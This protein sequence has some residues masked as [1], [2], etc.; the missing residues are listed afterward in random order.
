M[1]QLEADLIAQ[2]EQFEWQSLIDELR[3]LRGVDYI[4]AIT[5]VAEIGNLRRFRSA[6]QLMAYVDLVP[7]EYSS[8]GRQRRG[9]ITRTGNAAVR[10]ALIESAWTYRFPP[11]Q[12]R[13]LQRKAQNASKYARQ[14][15]WVAQKRLCGRYQTL[16]RAGKDKKT[17]VTAIARE[18]LGFIWDIGCHELHR[19]D[20]T[21]A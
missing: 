14:R 13:H 6:R 5:L 3:A 15:T 19:I 8:G 4:T 2:A 20:A 17:V 12:T 10:Q 9:A 11:R 16:Y 1:A 18:L 7:S 21:Q